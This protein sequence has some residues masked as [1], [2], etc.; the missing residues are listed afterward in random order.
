[1]EIDKNGWMPYDKGFQTRSLGRPRDSVDDSYDS[2]DRVRWQAGWDTA[3]KLSTK[4][5]TDGK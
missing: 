3:E 4:G 2:S 1:M 5:G